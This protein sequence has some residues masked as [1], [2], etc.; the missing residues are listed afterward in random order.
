VKHEWAIKSRF[1]SIWVA[2]LIRITREEFAVTSGGQIEEVKQ[3]LHESDIT[4][5]IVRDGKGK[6]LLGMPAK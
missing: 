4:R 1:C 2:V 6:T 5:I 3:L